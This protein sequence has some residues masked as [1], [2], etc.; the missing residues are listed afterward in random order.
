VIAGR[1]ADRL[2]HPPGVLPDEGGLGPDLDALGGE[3]VRLRTRDGLR[4]AARWLDATVAVPGEPDGWR[5]DPHEAILLLHGW[6]G[7]IAPDLL[8]YG[9]PL[10]RTAGVLG[11]DFRGHG[12]SDRSPTTF[13]LREVDDVAAALGWLA[14]RGVRHVAMV[15]SSMGG[16]TAIA[17]TV[18]L[19]D[20]RL[21]A[22]DADPDEPRLASMPPPPRIVALAVEGVPPDLPTSVA[23]R[24]PG[25]RPVRALLA[26]RALSAMARRLG[27]DPREAEPGR[28][29]GLLED[30]PVLLVSGGAD[31]TVPPAA[32]DRLVAAGGPGVQAW[33]VPGAG[34][35]RA[36]ATDPG[37]WE[38]RVGGLLRREFEA[39][40]S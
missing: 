34:H 15:G 29:I 1:L 24:L 13:G 6:S 17:A 5:P 22:V 21:T 12:G 27:A 9:P 36:H 28:I 8:E 19:G 32:A 11:L 26:R 37:G 25:P 40:R 7:S 30:L 2:L 23:N 20:G 10:R 3:I 39:A 16:I 31:R 18:L 33:R 38:A 4:L 14:E 35:G